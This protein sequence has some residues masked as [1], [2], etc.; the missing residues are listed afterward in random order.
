MNRAGMLRIGA[1]GIIG[2][3]AALL[4]AA[5]LL[6]TYTSGKIKKIPL[7]IDETLVSD[8]TGTA[9]DPVSLSGER[10]V[11]DK[12]VPLVS[13]QQITVESPANADVV[14]FQVGTSVRRSDKQQDNGLLL[15]MVDTVTLNRTTAMAMS[16]DTHPGGSVQKP[17]TLEDNKPPT[18]IALPH[19]GLSYR[20][21]FNTEKKTYPY[22]DPIAQKAFDANY[23]GEDDVNGLTTYR[24]TQNVGYDADGKLVE[25]LKYASLFDNAEDGEVTARASLWG[26]PGPPDEP[27]TM[28]RYYAAQRTFWVDPV[29]GTI[30]KSEEHANH[31]YARD[32]VRPE[33]EL[34]DYKVTSTEQTIESQVASARDERDRVGLWSRVL[35]I[36]FTA[37]GLVAL[38]GGILLGTFSV[39]AE[40]ALIDPGLDTADHGFF[41]KDETGPMPAAE[42][43][44]EKLPAAR[45]DLEPPPPQR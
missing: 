14:T 18:N 1:Y 32:P 26:L 31:Y 20:F 35:P 17:R 28:T 24:F 15:A 13:Q 42:A 2:L 36:S 30:V 3:G 11:I 34:A 27:V 10:F 38:V 7:N 5:L 21:P 45:P 39:R 6:S 23:D 44:T 29:T 33:M 19:E 37:A 4:I 41:G 8:G 12:N 16:D 25:P 22:F 43:A 9:L 40:S